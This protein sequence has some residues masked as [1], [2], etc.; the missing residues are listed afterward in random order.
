MTNKVTNIGAYY[1]LPCDCKF[2]SYNNGYIEKSMVDFF[3]KHSLPFYP[4]FEA[5]Q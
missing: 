1:E 4:G 2:Q 5:K 3:V